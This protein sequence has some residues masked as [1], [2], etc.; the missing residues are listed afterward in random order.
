M[1]FMNMKKYFLTIFAAALALL[2]ASCSDETVHGRVDQKNKSVQIPQPVEVTSVRSIAGGAVI[3]VKI[4]DDKYIKGVVATYDRH[5]EKVEARISRYVDSLSVEGFADT[6]EHDIEVCS[7]NVNE[8]KSEPVNVKITPNT[9]A[10]M[11]VKPIMYAATGGVKIYINGNFDKSDLA[12]CLLRD[13]VLSHENMPVSEMKWVEVT[14][15]FTASDD[16]TLTRRGLD[17]L[18]AIYGVYLRDHWG[19]ISDTT[20]AVLKP[21]EEI[22]IPKANFA[23]FDPGDDN[24][25]S[26]SSES[27]TY[28]MKGLW[29]GSGLSKS[30]YFLA[31]DVIPVP[32]WFTIDMGREVELSR[33]VT[34]PRQDY[35]ADIYAGGSPRDIEFWGSLKAPT[36]DVGSGEHGF[37]ENW[38]CLGKFT[39][40]KPSGYNADGTVGD[41]TQEDRDYFREK[42]EYE[43][44]DALY[45]HAY[46]RI[47]YLRIVV[48]ST[49]A[50]WEMPDATTTTIQF[51]EVTPYGQVFK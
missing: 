38:V 44:D 47:R 21:L 29:D 3:K 40:P 42:T 14:T 37:E 39:Q 16:I 48:V 6:E 17:T 18:K 1:N 25:F 5:G 26:I 7:F 50:S 43:L 45:P 32:C 27:S 28:P 20:T 49:F 34:W 30:P 15:L 46:D 11:T 41:I 51:G 8:E 24:I 4:P 22:Q 35:P 23:Y 33:I 2:A 12:V 19:N 10:I 36:G 9:P 13:T 31:V